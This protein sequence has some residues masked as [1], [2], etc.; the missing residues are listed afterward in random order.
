MPLT[1]HRPQDI[2]AIHLPMRGLVKWSHLRPILKGIL[3]KMG[4]KV[5]TDGKSIQSI[6]GGLHIGVG[7]DA[8]GGPTPFQV[9]ATGSAVTVRHGTVLGNVDTT[10]LDV[11]AGVQK[12]LTAS[13]QPTLAITTTGT[14]IV[15]IK[16][17]MTHTLDDSGDYVVGSAY[18]SSEV[19]EGASLPSDDKATGIYYKRLATLVDGAVETQWVTNNIGGYITDARTTSGDATGANLNTYADA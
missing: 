2:G 1:E 10:L 15:Y 4:I 18:V 14:R 3:G 5:S 16:I 19:K 13:P 8:A 17:T 9:K 12:L 6:E 7:G 11:T